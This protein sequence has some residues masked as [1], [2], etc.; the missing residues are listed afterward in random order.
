M[1]IK[2]TLLPPYYLTTRKAKQIQEILFITK[3]VRKI[4]C[5]FL[6]FNIYSIFQTHKT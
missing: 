4:L 3:K 1:F 6:R 5:L 2:I